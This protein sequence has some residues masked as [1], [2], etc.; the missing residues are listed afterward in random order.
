M[1]PFRLEGDSNEGLP[2]AM[3]LE[4]QGEDGQLLGR[5]NRLQIRERIYAGSLK[6]S[7]HVRLDGEN[8]E[9][10]GSRPEFAQ[11]L[12]LVGVDVAGLAVARQQ[13]KGWKRDA[14]AGG[15]KSSRPSPV[16]PPSEGVAPQIEIPDAVSNMNPRTRNLTLVL[17]LLGA[18][19]LLDF[20]MKSF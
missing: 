9:A 14:S 17:L 7:E 18:I 16:P 19:W 1:F 6:G 15:N 13:V 10:I 4:V 8:W 5:M 11:I 12:A 20:F 3:E 2:P